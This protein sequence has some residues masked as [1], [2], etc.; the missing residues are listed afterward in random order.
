MQAVDPKHEQSLLRLVEEGAT[1][2]LLFVTA[3]YPWGKEGTSLQDQEGPDEWQQDVLDQIARGSLTMNEAVQ[4]AVSSGHGIGKTALVAWIIHWFMSTRPHPQIVVTANT[5]NQLNGKTWRE[6]AKWH[7]LASNKHWFT[8]TAT[9]FFH[10]KHPE[11]WFAQAVPWSENNSEAFAGT[12]EEHVLVV[13]DEASAISDT[14]W[15][16]AEGAMTTPGAMWIA[17]GNPTRNTGRFRE[18]FGKFAHRWETRKVDSRTAKMTNKKQLAQWESDYGED[19]DFFRIRVRGEFP[20]AG[21][22]QFIS[23]SVC[24]EAVSRYADESNAVNPLVMGVDCA[25]YGDD[26]SVI[27]L[28][29]GRKV[30]S[31]RRFRNLDTMQLAAVAAGMINAHRPDTT[32][33]DGGGL[34]AGVVDRLKQMGHPVIDVIAA[35]APDEE[36]KDTCL[37]KRA[38]MWLRMKDWLETADIPHDQE[39]IDELCSVEYFHNGRDKLQLEKK[40]DMKKRGQPSPDSADALAMTFA[41]PVSR[42]GQ[43]VT[44]YELLDFAPADAIAGF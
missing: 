22:R 31:I 39:L 8:W 29:R 16:V 38:E 9:K 13:F 23:T 17:F 28:R 11:T 5:Q 24:F 40:S 41:Y 32:F 1:D 7:K 12:H 6:L 14:I 34:G 35:A 33:V 37:N 15:E 44:T 26:Q 4:I 19:S 25:R 43:N 30:E 42:L 2:P 18:C 20:R 21:D 27:I 10:K 3:V 36:N